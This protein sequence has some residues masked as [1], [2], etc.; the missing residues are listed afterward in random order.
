MRLEQADQFFTRRDRLAVQH[1]ALALVEDA[2]DQRQIMVDLGA[3]ARGRHA[4]HGGQPVD[5]SLQGRPGGMRGG[6]QLAVEPAPG[7][8]AAAI[9]DVC[10]AALR[11]APAVMPAERRRSR[12]F[13]RLAQQPRHHAHGIPQ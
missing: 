13:G 12:Q 1:P 7:V 9:L 3:P 10:G 5:G 4:G 11:Q 6:D 2:R 8:F